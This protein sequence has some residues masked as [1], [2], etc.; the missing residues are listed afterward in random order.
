M[1]Y[2][3]EEFSY[4]LWDPEKKRIIRSRDLVFHEQATI[5]ILWFQ[6][7]LVNLVVRSILHQP[8]F[9][10]KMPQK[11]ESYMNIG[12]IM[13]QLLMMLEMEEGQVRGASCYTTAREI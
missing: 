10:E 5:Q 3:D 2:R 4:R 9:L 7:K 1:S 6:R 13:S 8:F 11:G 12:L